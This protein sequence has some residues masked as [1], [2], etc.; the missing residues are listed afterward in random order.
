MNFA[1]LV[2]GFS[3]SF[4]ALA[5]NG[6][7]RIGGYVASPASQSPVRQVTFTDPFRV[8][9]GKRCDLRQQMTWDATAGTSGHLMAAWSKKYMCVD[10]ID[11]PLVVLKE[12]QNGFAVAALTNYPYI[13]SLKDDA[14]I[15][16]LAVE[17]SPVHLSNGQTLTLYDYG[18]I[19]TEQVAAPAP[20]STNRHVPGDGPWFP[21][22]TN[23]R[24][25][26]PP[27]N[28]SK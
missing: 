25:I 3:F 11:G 28:S 21:L 5:Q 23:R 2:A 20:A 15:S 27:K 13:K 7:Q 16:F 8:I 1:A 14:Y 6:Y 26:T 9:D 24:V 10:K 12:Y 4:S 19:W 17:R 22:D 18:R